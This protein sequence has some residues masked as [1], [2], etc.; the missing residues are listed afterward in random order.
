MAIAIANAA[1]AWSLGNEGSGDGAMN[2]WVSDVGPGTIREAREEL[3][4]CQGEGGAQAGGDDPV[5][6]VSRSP[7]SA[8]EEQSGEQRDEE[9]LTVEG[10]ELQH[11]FEA[12]ALIG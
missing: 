1:V 10:D 8:R 12:V 11:V 9:I 7:L 6:G 5:P 2:R 4:D 3:G